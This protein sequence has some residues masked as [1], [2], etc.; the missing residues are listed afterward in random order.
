MKESF[1]IDRLLRR[2]SHARNRAATLCTASCPSGYDDGYTGFELG[3]YATNCY[4]V[5]A[6]DAATCWIV[7][8]GFDPEPLIEFVRT[9]L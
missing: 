5:R 7:D 4:V 2:S 1:R 6:A 8:A 9:I 3:P